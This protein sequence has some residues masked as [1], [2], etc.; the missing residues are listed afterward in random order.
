MVLPDSYG[1]P[2]A[3]QYL[4]Q[5]RR[6]RSDFAYETITPCGAPFQ[7]SSAIWRFGNSSGLSHSPTKRPT[8]PDRQR[9]RPITSTRFRLFPVRSP[10]LGES[11][12]YFLFLGLLRWFSWPGPL[13]TPYAAFYGRFQMAMTAYYRCRVAPF[14]YLRI[15]AR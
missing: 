10:L 4:G 14:G 3:P 7:A 9:L 1:I 13:R 6:D 15:N 8:T 11:L 2:R 5:S 12:A